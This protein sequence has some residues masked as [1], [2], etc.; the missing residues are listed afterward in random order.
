MPFPSAAFTW[1]TA[2][3]GFP[4][5][6]HMGLDLVMELVDGIADAASTWRRA[7]WNRISRLTRFFQPRPELSKAALS[8]V[9]ALLSGSRRRSS[10]S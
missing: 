2:W 5:R 10:P 1:L 4:E 9:T 6:F 8:V 3:G 7:R